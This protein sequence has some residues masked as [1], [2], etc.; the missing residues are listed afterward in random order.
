MKS[1][2]LRKK[3]LKF[4]EKKGHKVLPSSSLISENDP[5]VLLTTAGMQQ[6]KRWFS[7]LEKPAYPRVATIQKCVRVGDIEEVGDDTHLSFFEMLG[8]FS[9]SSADSTG[10]QRANLELANSFCK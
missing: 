2:E 5:S 7:G 6:F 3:F 10:S 1:E 4:F 8:N 9:F